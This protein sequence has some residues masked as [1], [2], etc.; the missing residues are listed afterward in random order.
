[1]GEALFD[2]N[3]SIVMKRMKTI[4]QDAHI[5]HQKIWLDA[6]EFYEEYHFDPMPKEV[7]DFLATSFLTIKETGMSVEDYSFTDLRVIN[8]LLVTATCWG[9]DDLI[10]EANINDEFID[11]VEGALGNQG[12]LF[13]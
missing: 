13:L 6:M 11:A 9:R 2:F 3:D 1:M 10:S 5:Y 4:R 8:S 7:A 12:G